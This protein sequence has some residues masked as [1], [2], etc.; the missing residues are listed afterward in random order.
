MSKYVTVRLTVAQAEALNSAVSE[1]QAGDAS[2]WTA[3][4]WAA[5]D[6]ARNAIIDGLD[7]ATGRKWRDD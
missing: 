7:K 6:R 2:H 5:L 1:V 3:A 4:R